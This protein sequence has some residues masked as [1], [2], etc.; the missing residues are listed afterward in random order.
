MTFR[1]PAAPFVFGADITHFSIL[2]DMPPTI[3]IYREMAAALR[4]EAAECR[5]GMR[6][7]G[8]QTRV[9]IMKM[10]AF[11]THYLLPSQSAFNIAGSHQHED[12]YASRAFVEPLVDYYSVPT[13]A[14]RYHHALLSS[15]PNVPLIAGLPFEHLHGWRAVTILPS[16]ACD[17]R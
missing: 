1:M 15:R 4:H 11:C 6:K 13:N 7:E 17:L 14:H 16:P 5:V 8:R 12:K 10:T 2:I 9:N 3:H